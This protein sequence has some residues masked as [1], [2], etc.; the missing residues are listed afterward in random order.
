MTVASGSGNV[1]SSSASGATIIWFS[2]GYVSV[3][4]SY[5]YFNQ[6]GQY[7]SQTGYYTDYVYDGNF[8]VSGISGPTNIPCTSGNV[9]FSVTP[10][11]GASYVWNVAQVSVDIGLPLGNAPSTGSSVTL[12]P[13]NSNSGQGTITVTVTRCGTSRS[14]TLT[15]YRSTPGNSINGNNTICYNQTKGYTAAGPVGSGYVWS[16]T[17]PFVVSS[18]SGTTCNVLAP[19]YSTSGVVRVT[20]TDACGNST[21][22]TKPIASGSSCSARIAASRASANVQVFPN[23]ASDVLEINP[24][25]EGCEAKLYNSHLKIVKSDVSRSGTMRMNV[26]DLPSGLYHLELFTASGTTIR[27]KII[28]R[29]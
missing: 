14:Q 7:V 5:Y 13:T 29:H 27:K 18:Q 8:T 6:S 2:S 24:D 21:T 17:S 22:L 20:F 1:Q 4:Y 11:P 25:T 15:V 10:V 19:G 28:V 23:P 26:K 3:G 9:V 12:A 16:A